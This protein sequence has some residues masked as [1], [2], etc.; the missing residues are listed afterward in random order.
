MKYSLKVLFP[1]L[2]MLFVSC[3]TGTIENKESKGDTS[4]QMAFRSIL[5]T[6]RSNTNTFRVITE[7][8]DTL[9][10]T[11]TTTTE[12]F[13]YFKTTV[14][15]VVKTYAS[16]TT[17]PPPP[18]PGGSYGTLIY[19]SKFDT[20]KELDPWGNNQIGNGSLSSSVYKSALY[21][22]KSVPAN[23]SSGIRSE[24]QFPDN[25]T[26]AEG[27]IEYDVLYETI[28]QNSGHSLQFHPF[29]SGGSASPGL[30]HE[31]GY[32]M[33]VNWKNGTNTKY[34]TNFKIPQNKWMHVVFEYK[35][36]SSGYMKFTVD[37]VVL[38]NKTGI[39]VGDNSGAYLKVGVN[40]WQNQ[41]SVVYYDNL[42]I[43][44]K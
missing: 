12:T 11:V 44:K 34:P 10:I 2:I 37:G 18:D 5:P 24:I 9:Q 7:K 33:W 42:K 15:T 28:F 13:T 8:K 36:G 29:T 40:M 22:F 32:F 30:W 31:N 17:P 23:V 25:L 39:Q 3:N 19:S 41:S 35:M 14:D 27:T 21:S 20:Q 1:V 43:W 38:L 26:P 16:N 4:A 6:D